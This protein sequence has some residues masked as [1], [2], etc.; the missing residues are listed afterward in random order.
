MRDGSK[1]VESSPLREMIERLPERAAKRSAILSR[2]RMEAS[3]L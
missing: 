1:V 2:R 3:C